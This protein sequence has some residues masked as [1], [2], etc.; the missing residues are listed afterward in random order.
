MTYL[1]SWIFGA[2]DSFPK[3][4]ELASIRVGLY[5]ILATEVEYKY[6]Q[7]ARLI[8]CPSDAVPI[9]DG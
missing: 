2:S 6:R 8:A 9:A 5:I 7:E 4:N 1:F 3:K